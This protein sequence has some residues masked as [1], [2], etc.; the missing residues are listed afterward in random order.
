MTLTAPEKVIHI[1]HPVTNLGYATLI[2][3][4]L[5]MLSGLAVRE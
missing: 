4:I 3:S 1:M 2:G 5:Y